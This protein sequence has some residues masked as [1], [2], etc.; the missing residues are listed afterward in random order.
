[1]TSDSLSTA[2]ASA[3]AAELDMRPSI[4]DLEAI[5]VEFGIRDGMLDAAI[6]ELAH[7]W[8]ANRFNDGDLPELEFWHAYDQLHDEADEN[9]SSLNDGGVLVQLQVL[10]EGCTRDALRSLLRDLLTPA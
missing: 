4:A 1:M 2:E 9:A 10:S 3:V 7:E 6:E 8:A 5:A